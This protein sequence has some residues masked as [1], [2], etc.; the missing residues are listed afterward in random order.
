MAATMKRCT[1]L[2]PTRGMREG[3]LFG[4]KWLDLHWSTGVIYAQRQVQS[5]HGKGKVFLEPKT[6][7]G[8]RAIKLGEGVLHKLRIYK[9][10]QELAN[11]LAGNRWMENDLMFPTRLGTPEDPGNLRERFHPH[12]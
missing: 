5:V 10:Q 12:T 7:A 11:A 3:G 6:R 1:T 4:L 2:R 8:R 9:E